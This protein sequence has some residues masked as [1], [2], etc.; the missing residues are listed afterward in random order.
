MFC[1]FIC[2]SSLIPG[3][4]L[5]FNCPLLTK[6]ACPIT[7][8]CVTVVVLLGMRKKNVPRPEPMRRMSKRT[9]SSMNNLLCRLLETDVGAYDGTGVGGATRTGGACAGEAPTLLFV[10]V[11]GTLRTDAAS[12]GVESAAGA[13]DNG[14]PLV[15]KGGDDDVTLVDRSVC[16]DILWVTASKSPVGYMD[17]LW[18]AAVTSPS[19]SCMLIAWASAAAINETLGNRSNGSLAR[20]HRMT[21]AR[22]GEIAGL[23]RAG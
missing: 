11:V 16:D 4:P 5:S 13:G 3:M 2:N 7:E 23:M 17:R 19:R 15:G 9:M 21:S 1:K 8:R 22:A 6:K 20:L 10:G 14:D 12:W 18:S